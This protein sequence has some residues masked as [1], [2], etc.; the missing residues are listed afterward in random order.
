[1]AVLH[2]LLGILKI[3]GILLAV[4]LGLLLLILSCML[5]CPVVY[6]GAGEKN[7]DSLKGSLKISWLFRGISLKVWYEEG[8]H[9]SVRICGISTEQ[10]KRI[11]KRRAG[12]KTEK[13]QPKELTAVQENS[14]EAKK[15][16]YTG[17]SP[18][19]AVQKETE[20]AEE[21]VSPKEKSKRKGIGRSFA[22]FRLTIEKICDK[23][24]KSKKNFKVR[25]DEA[26]KSM[27]AERN[28]VLDFSYKTEKIAG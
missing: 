16:E 17:Q 15:R 23:I 1:M 18:R 5:F 4:L 3:A 10:F 2:I 27:D 7:Q 20:K 24:K 28:Q 12:K 25:A 21:Q 22:D 19:E 14:G 11:F 6:Q 13:K 26:N 8:T 9:Y